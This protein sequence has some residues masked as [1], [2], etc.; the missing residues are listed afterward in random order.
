MI[1]FMSLNTPEIP[2]PLQNF[3]VL[4]LN[5]MVWFLEGSRG[6]DFDR[7]E[8]SINIEKFWSGSGLPGV[9][10]IIEGIMPRKVFFTE[11]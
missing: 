11:K 2:D 7:S 5:K 10:Q 9:F 3:V 1:P 4:V 6:C 8:L